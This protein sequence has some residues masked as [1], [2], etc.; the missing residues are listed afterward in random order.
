MVLIRKLR[1]QH[2]ELGEAVAALLAGIRDPDGPD[3]PALRSGLRAFET[4]VRA[5]LDLEDSRFYPGARAHPDP[6]ISSLATRYWS[7]MG[8]IR[9]LVAGYLETWMVERRI[10]DDPLG[11]QRESEVIFGFLLR[12]VEREERDLYPRL[13]ADPGPVD[14][15]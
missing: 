14:E 10:E 15:G 8:H 12:R 5:H 13:E 11:F 1:Q 9:D 2:A 4:A 3:G 6:E 7:N